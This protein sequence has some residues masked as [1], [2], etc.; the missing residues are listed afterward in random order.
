ME[1]EVAKLGGAVPANDAGPLT[2]WTES[3]DVRSLKSLILLGL[4]GTAPTRARARAGA[5]GRKRQRVLLE[6]LRAV[7]D[8]NAT[9]DKLLPLVLKT[10]EINLKCM[11]L[12][13]RANTDAY[14]SPVPTTVPLTIE[15]GPFI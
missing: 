7:G 4:R 5:G 1:E 11:E 13:D 9:V 12:L 14:G 3:E 15:K 6:G 2:L 10:G 8:P